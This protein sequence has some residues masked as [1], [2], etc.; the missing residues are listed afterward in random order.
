MPTMYAEFGAKY[1][2]GIYKCLKN[3]QLETFLNAKDIFSTAF[4]I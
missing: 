2:F 3:W 4:G 1:V